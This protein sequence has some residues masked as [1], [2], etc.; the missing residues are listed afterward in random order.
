MTQPTGYPDV[1]MDEFGVGGGIGELTAG[2]FHRYHRDPYFDR[3]DLL[4]SGRCKWLA[5]VGQ[6]PL[7]ALV[8]RRITDRY[9][10]TLCTPRPNECR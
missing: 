8:Q 5:D 1:V 6:V 10:A 2:C 9:M 7:C 4:I 3:I